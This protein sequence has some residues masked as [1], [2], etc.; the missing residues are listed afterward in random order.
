MGGQDSLEKPFVP[1]AD[2]EEPES[3]AAH[4]AT[5]IRTRARFL[6]LAA[7]VAWPLAPLWLVHAILLVTRLRAHRG[8]F[9]RAP[10]S[11]AASGWTAAAILLCIAGLALDA[12]VI[13]WLA[14]R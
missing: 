1:G 12:W 2:Q 4:D 5:T 9:G 13:W 14:A 3:L 10:L 8:A 11:R 7:L 6:F